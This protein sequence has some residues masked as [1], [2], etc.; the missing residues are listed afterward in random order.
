MNEDAVVYIVDDDQAM[1][2]SLSWMVESVGFK[3]KT[4]SNAK[5][6]LEV[7]KEFGSFHKYI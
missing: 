5:S 1:T 4:F 3:T 2:E 6:F 7:Q